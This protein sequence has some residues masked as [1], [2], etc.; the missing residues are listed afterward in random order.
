MNIGTAK[1]D[2]VS[3]CPV[4]SKLSIPR[5]AEHDRYYIIRFCFY[6]CLFVYL[7][8][9]LFVCLCQIKCHFLNVF[10]FWVE[11]NYFYLKTF[12]SVLPILYIYSIIT[13]FCHCFC[14]CH[15][16]VYC[17]YYYY[18]HYYFHYYY[19]CFDAKHSTSCKKG[20]WRGFF[21][22]PAGVQQTFRKVNSWTM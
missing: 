8:V 13:D 11:I 4:L 6:L 10:L 1:A 14:C 17:Y 20:N 9:C 5:I 18:Y 21:C 22:S 16:Y 2:I 3:N 12:N 15:H 19:H 7:F